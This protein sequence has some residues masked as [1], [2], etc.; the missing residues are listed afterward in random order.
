MR[1]PDRAITLRPCWA[2]AVAHASKRIENRSWPTKFRGPI[3]IHA[4]CS[5]MSRADREDFARCIALAGGTV[6]ADVDL[7]RGALVA[8]AVIA[9]CV[10]LPERELGPW[11]YAGSWHFLLEDVRALDRPRPMLGKLGIWHL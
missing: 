10:K 2:W 11:G 9:D 6:P 1:A 3:Y 5:A 4:G 8:T 7:V